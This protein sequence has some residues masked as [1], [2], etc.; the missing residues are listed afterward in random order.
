VESR[1]DPEGSPPGSDQPLSHK[2]Y[3]FIT[4][5]VVCREVNFLLAITVMCAERCIGPAAALCLL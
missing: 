4:L 3:I 1:R 2:P 5:T